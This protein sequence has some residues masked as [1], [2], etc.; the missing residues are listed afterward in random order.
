[1]SYDRVVTAWDL[2]PQQATS[3]LTWAMGLV[4][5]AIRDGRGPGDAPVT[6]A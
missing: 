3:A 6:Q 2:T 4:E 5:A 1:M